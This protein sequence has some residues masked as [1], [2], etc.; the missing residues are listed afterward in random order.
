MRTDKENIYGI[1]SRYLAGDA[2][3]KETS[4][5]KSWLSEDRKN[6]IEFDDLVAIWNKSQSLQFPKKINTYKA[7]YSV[8][9]KG[10]IKRTSKIFRL[11]V[12]QQ[13]A[14]ILILSVLLTGLYT[15]FFAG[16]DET[17]HE[18]GY[19]QEVLAAYGTRTN[20]DLPD[21]TTVI[22]NSGSSLRFSSVFAKNNMRRVE[23]RGEGY[24]EVAKDTERPFIVNAGKID[25][26]VLG[27][28]FNVN[29]YDVEPDV[30]IVLVEG[31]VAIGKANSN[32]SDNI[33]ALKP[34]Q[35]ARFNISENKIYK[36]TSITLEKHIGWVEGKMIFVDDPIMDVVKRLENW[37]N[38]DIKIADEQLL[39]YRFT[40]TFVN[41]SLEGILSAF[42]LT[43]PLRYDIKP[44]TKDDA[45]KY[46]KRII[47]LKM[48]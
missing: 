45:G 29:A 35:L 6:Q 34:N 14:A 28:Q 27:T 24:F 40:G 10:G 12:I 48:K 42:S 20:V 13:I 23:L 5:L 38:T 15:Y 41:E 9:T 2:S 36:E 31:E 25:I 33:M 16:D 17:F 11:H 1:I 4:L 22:L 19:Y 21:G 8:H 43:S 30:N 39:K 7:L 3:D 18:S 32:F 47:T 26:K 37:Y 44:A 46:T